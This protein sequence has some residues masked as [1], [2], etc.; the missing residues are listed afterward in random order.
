MILAASQPI[1]QVPDALSAAAVAIFKPRWIPARLARKILAPLGARSDSDGFQLLLDLGDVQI[2]TQYNAEAD[3]SWRVV[4]RVTGTGV[5][6]RDG[7]AINDNAER[8]AFSAK[9][10]ED[11]GFDFRVAE[12]LYRVQP[13]SDYLKETD[14]F[15]N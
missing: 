3:S 8:F 6:M 11:T 1:S 5:A 4:G 13:A 7:E 15:G 10:L 14:A 12:K 9:R 2:R